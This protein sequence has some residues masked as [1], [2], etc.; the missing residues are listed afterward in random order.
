MTPKTLRVGL[1]V[2]ANDVVDVVA[3]CIFAHSL[4]LL[5]DDVVSSPKTFLVLSTTSACFVVSAFV[6]AC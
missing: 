5:L 3:I 4:H 1:Q 2:R 6:F